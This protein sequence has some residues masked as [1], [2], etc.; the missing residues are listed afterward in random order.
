MVP[1]NIKHYDSVMDIIFFL[2][3]FLRCKEYSI[4]TEPKLSILLPS[5][6]LLVNLFVNFE[7][8]VLMQNLLKTAGS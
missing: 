5:L 4:I 8:L 3:Y 2:L 1:S 6:N 7:G